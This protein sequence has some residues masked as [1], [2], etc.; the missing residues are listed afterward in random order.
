[1]RR[2]ISRTHRRLLLPPL[3]D[4][5]FS[6][7]LALKSRIVRDPIPLSA[8]FLS[9][10]RGVRNIQIDPA[11]CPLLCMIISYVDLLYFLDDCAV[12]VGSGRTAK[13]F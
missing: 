7:F 11:C 5:F 8:H 2:I 10:A 1:M 12:D 9:L 13:L 4:F 3:H 6:A